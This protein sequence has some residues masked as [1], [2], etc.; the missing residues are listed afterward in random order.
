MYVSSVFLFPTLYTLNSLFRAGV[1]SREDTGEISY[2]NAWLAVLNALLSFC[3]K[4]LW[5][6]GL[7][8]GVDTKTK[9]NTI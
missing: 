5:K 6:I 3:A 7:T 4:W 8:Q 9:R 2:L 1:C